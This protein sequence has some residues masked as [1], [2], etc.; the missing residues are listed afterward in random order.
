MLIACMLCKPEP[1]TIHQPSLLFSLRDYCDV[2][3][4]WIEHWRRIMKLDE[5]SGM[6]IHDRK[7]ARA[8]S[9]WST[10]SMV[11]HFHCDWLALMHK[12][13]LTECWYIMIQKYQSHFYY[14]DS[15]FSIALMISNAKRW[16]N[17]VAITSSLWDFSQD[18]FVL[19][20]I[21]FITL[22]L[23]WTMCTVTVIYVSASIKLLLR[24][25]V[26]NHSNA[27]CWE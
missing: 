11:E 2:E 13:S 23:F 24:I 3:R 4:I 20:I 8:S 5:Q 12:E 26:I 21:D 9:K 6:R 27:H 25:A 10:A 18:S 22:T 15:D 16:S 14:M 7:C 1:D 17:T 19:L